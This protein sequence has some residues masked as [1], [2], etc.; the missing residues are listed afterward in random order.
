MIPTNQELQKRNRELISITESTEILLTGEDFGTSLESV[1][2]RIGEAFEINH[3][4]L[5]GYKQ[6]EVKQTSEFSL[7]A[8]SDFKKIS[9]RPDPMIEFAEDLNLERHIDQLSL[10]NPVKEIAGNLLTTM[11]HVKHPLYQMQVLVMPVFVA[12]VF[13][14]LWCLYRKT[15]CLHGIKMQKRTSD[16]SPSYWAVYYIIKRI[17]N[18]WPMP[19]KELPMLTLPNP[20][21]SQP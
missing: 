15:L 2:S 21:F 14:G 9:D 13:W 19:C 10:G 18:K 6:K 3:L 8:H 20:A 5:F 1:L 16:I 17:V 12:D 4:L 11:R 7:F